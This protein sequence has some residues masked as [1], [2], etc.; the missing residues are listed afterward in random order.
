MSKISV[1]IAATIA[2][3]V[4]YLIGQGLGTQPQ[5][6][7]K[8]P[9]AGGEARRANNA[10]PA[11]AAAREAAAPRPGR[12]DPSAT[13]RALVGNSPARG[14]TAAKITVVEWSDFECPYC[15]RLN[16]PLDALV[17][18]H[19][20]EVR[21]VYKQYPLPNHAHAE[22]AAEAS[23]AA[24]A[25]GK[26][27]QMQRALFSHQSALDRQALEGYAAEIGLDVARFKGE[28]DS[29]KWKAAVAAEAAEG[30]RLGVMGTPS[31][32]LNGHFHEGYVDA[33]SLES[34]LQAALTDADARLKNGTPRARLYDAIMQTAKAEVEAPPLLE[35]EVRA[36]DPG[37]QAPSRGRA[38]APVTIV[39]FSDFQCPYC[40]RAADLLTDVQARYGDDVRVV[41]RN[42][43]LPY[44]TNASLAAQAALAAHAQGKFWQMHDQLFAHQNALDRAAIDGFAREL[45]LDMTRFAAALDGGK[46]TSS[47]NADVAAGQPFVDG[48][49]TLFVNGHKL[50]NPALLAQ[51]VSAEL[52]HSRK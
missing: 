9:A 5:H 22:L 52:E 47:V 40:K 2:L 10:A 51:A 42:F 34:E 23:L 17:K 19:P 11:R 43:P 1:I 48:T 36:V 16:D 45:G 30:Q 41:F 12:P 7:A 13:Y 3:V 46:L 29:G 6:S 50:T 33:A 31:F 35:R 4:G 20:D 21:I 26:F 37:P 14:A 28:L 44:H 15:A 24:H 8:P 38:R 39:E 27:W 49:P 18:A 32:F 25:Q